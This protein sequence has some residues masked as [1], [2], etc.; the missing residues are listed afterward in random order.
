MLKKMYRTIIKARA[1]SAAIKVVESMTDALLLDIGISRSKFP[2]EAM[3][4]VEAD[5][6]RKDLENQD[7]RS[8]RL[9]ANLSAAT[10]LNHAFLQTNRT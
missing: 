6:A 2:V 9:S 4:A 1:A 3:K 5:F 8:A 10:L 7:K